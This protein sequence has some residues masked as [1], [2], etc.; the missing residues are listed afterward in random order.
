MSSIYDQGETSQHTWRACEDTLDD[1]CVHK[2][3]QQDLSRTIDPHRCRVERIR[4]SA[5]SRT[6]AITGTWYLAPYKAVLAA[7]RLRLFVWHCGRRR[8]NSIR[9]KRRAFRTRNTRSDLE[10]CGPHPRTTPRR[11]NIFHG[12]LPDLG[13]GRLISHAAEV[14]E[15]DE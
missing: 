5:D 13:F 12:V 10:L 15:G 4:A 7:V 1:F 2:I 6:D 11:T 9:R 3:L 14:T 8:L